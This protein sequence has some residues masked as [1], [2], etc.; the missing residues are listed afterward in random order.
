MKYFGHFSPLHCPDLCSLSHEPLKT[1]HS[2]KN[3][4]LL[5]ASILDSFQWEKCYMWC[6]AFQRLTTWWTR[7]L[8]KW[9]LHLYK[10]T[11]QPMQ[12]PREE[13]RLIY[14]RTTWL[15]GFI[16]NYI[17]QLYHKRICIWFFKNIKQPKTAKNK[18]NKF[19][20]PRTS[21]PI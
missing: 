14:G 21:S 1:Y 7:A 13:V 3:T 12:C 5:A 6:F 8:Y 11:S 20:L 4:T 10:D 19:Q 15:V 17:A 16:E 9:N 18:T 2:V